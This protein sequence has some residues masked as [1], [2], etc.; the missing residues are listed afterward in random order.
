MPH[1]Y[2]PLLPYHSLLALAPFDS[3]IDLL[4][5]LV[6][7]LD[8]LGVVHERA[9]HRVE[10]NGERDAVVAL[11]L[12]VVQPVEVAVRRGL[13]VPVVPSDGSD[14]GVELGVQKHQRVAREEQ[15]RQ[16]R[17]GVVQEMFDRVHR[18]ARPRPWVKRLVVQSMRV[19]VEPRPHVAV[20]QTE[21]A[22][23]PRMHAAVAP[24]KV[25][26]PPVRDRSD[27]ADRVEGG[28]PEGCVVVRDALRCP[29]P[30]P[31]DLPRARLQP[32][33]RGVRH[34]AP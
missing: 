6:P 17:A 28:A 18:Q 4:R 24:I 21:A 34:L 20:E 32:P 33:Q 13:P 29:Q 27:T 7:V 25:D 11:K 26:L 22:I 16:P 15:R 19:S 12:R 3:G 9:E 5:D 31:Y 10:A 30:C 23:P 1:A 8:E 2:H 14:V